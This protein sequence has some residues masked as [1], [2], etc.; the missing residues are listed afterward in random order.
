MAEYTS[1]AHYG[2]GD[3]FTPRGRDAYFVILGSVTG[4]GWCGGKRPLSLIGVHVL[5]LRIKLLIITKQRD[6]DWG[7]GTAKN[8][9]TI[10][11]NIKKYFFFK[12]LFFSKNIFY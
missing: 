5:Q 4:R 10:I 9:K 2:P 1:A 3:L 7:T 8:K 12:K 11:S 6:N